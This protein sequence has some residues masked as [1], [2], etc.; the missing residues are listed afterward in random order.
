MKRHFPSIIPRTMSGFPISFRS[1]SPK[2]RLIFVSPNGLIPFHIYFLYSSKVYKKG[3][4]N[5]TPNKAF[6]RTTER[7][8]KVRNIIP[9]NSKLPYQYIIDKLLPINN[10]SKKNQT[11]LKKNPTFQEILDTFS[12][13]TN[14]QKGVANFKHAIFIAVA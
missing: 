3:P 13:C 2:S 11:L 7:H 12:F 4:R 8:Q 5:S 6:V 9:P 10:D 14:R 1:K